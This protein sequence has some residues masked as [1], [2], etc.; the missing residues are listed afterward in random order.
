MT[1]IQ[2]RVQHENRKM[3]VDL[4]MLHLNFIFR[5]MKEYA[6]SV[7]PNKL[8]QCCCNVVAFNDVNVQNLYSTS[9][10]TN[11]LLQFRDGSELYLKPK[12]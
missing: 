11:F 5:L 7:C 6:K 12:L 3:H 8:L 10:N 2:I 1:L 4:F 9:C